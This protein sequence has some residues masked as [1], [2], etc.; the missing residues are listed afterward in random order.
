MTTKLF[1]MLSILPAALSA[2]GLASHLVDQQ[3]IRFEENRG[4]AAAEYQYLGRTPEGTL[5]LTPSGMDLLLK[6]DTVRTRL[7]G[8]NPDASLEPLDPLPVRT[9]YFRGSDSRTWKEGIANYARVRYRS[10]YQGI[11]AVFY[12][13]R[14]TL[15]Y[16][17]EISPGADPAAIE[18]E[19][20]GCDRLRIEPSGDLVMSTAAG[21]V[22]WKKPEIR[23]SIRGRQTEV[24][25]GYVLKGQ[26]VTL[27]VGAYDRSLPLIVDPVLSFSTYLGSVG[28]EAIRGM[29]TDTSG[30]IYVTGSTT[31]TDLPAAGLQKQFA[32]K[33]STLLG[34]VTIGD[35][36]VAKFSPSGS[37]LYLT[38]LGGS[39]EDVGSALAVDKSG[40]V[41]VTGYTDSSDFPVTSSAAQ[42]TW[43]GRGGNLLVQLGDAFVA[44]IGP[45]GNQL[46]YSTFLGGRNDDYGSAIVLDASG[47]AYI[48]GGTLSADLPVSSNAAQT[49]YKR[50]G[51]QQTFPRFNAPLLTS[52]DAF[53]AKINSAGTSVLALTYLGGS[54]DELA[55]ALAL[56]S[57]G[58]LYV[59]GNTLSTD[60]PTTSGAFQSRFAGSD[61]TNNI[62]FNLGDGFVTKLTGDLSTILYST[63]LGGAGDDAVSAI[64]IDS[65]GNAYVTGATTSS[66]LATATAFGRSY[67]GPAGAPV[68]DQLIGDA[69]VAKIAPDGKSLGFFTYLGGSS[70]DVGM[71]IALDG[72][73]NIV[74][75]GS[76]QS[77]NF[78]TSS[79]ALQSKSP[80]AT[81]QVGG[82]GPGFLSI[83]DPTGKTLIY[84]SYFGGTASDIPTSLAIDA[85]GAILVAGAA[86]SADFPTAKAAQAKYGGGSSD[87]FVARF[88]GFGNTG[89][90]TVPTTPSTSAAGIAN[91]ASYQSGAISPGEITVIFGANMGP[92][93]LA[94]LTVSGGK[95]DS[96]LAG[97]K[98]LFDGAA[99]PLIYTS[100][101]QLAA[102]VPYGVAGRS[103]TQIVIQYNGQNSTPVSMPVAAAVPGLF[104][105]DKSGKG[106]GA[107]L[108]QDSSVNG[109]GNPA[110]RDSIVVL[111]LTGEG[112]TNPPG[113]DGL[114][115]SSVYP[116]PL[117]P[118]TVTIGGQV[119]DPLYAGAAPDEV[120]GVMQVNVTVPSGITPGDAV[121]V[122]VTVGGVTTPAG[123]TLAVK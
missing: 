89:G 10:I 23:Q 102:I 120:A 83:I 17:F 1:L 123:V 79:D 64:A 108:N 5:A 76:T 105:A 85:T 27:R 110:A 46:L 7:L 56:D 65:A 42:K 88:T 71:A 72:S 73:G 28:N 111:F 47:D 34:V 12:S 29:A 109:P 53:I 39:A 92:S 58:S 81:A 9:S 93:Q 19:F 50:S 41:Y 90:G 59:A 30:N 36:F 118:V 35:A 69:F 94:T 106:Q 68:A 87:G 75:T 101:A 96:T 25:G 113:T 117:L 24:P 45:D 31:S 20:G 98:V 21:D 99:A 86:T 78:P 84:S 44:K 40:N 112:Q 3:P 95:I 122:T 62:F 107:I 63:Y 114:I 116:A 43:A 54:Y 26:V 11:D 32:G 13:R 15:E 51:T 38:Y 33:G 115:A 4:Q 37:L 100:A 82:G 80:Q 119:V 57:N 121:P 49:T 55:W 48:A 66:N 70:D 61:L 8:A 60:F 14:S 67:K 2:A 52:G 91:V 74:V 104:T 22:R 97:T 77:L 103:S 6:D 18:L 16:D